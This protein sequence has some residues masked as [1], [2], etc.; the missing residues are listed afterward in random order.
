MSGLINGDFG[1]WQRGSTL[2]AETGFRFGPDMW[3]VNSTGSRVA[4]HRERFL[5]SQT[6]VP[7]N[8][9]YHVGITV[10]SI[11]GSGN[12]ARFGQPIE[13]VRRYAGETVTWSFHA[14][15]DTS[16][17]IA[18][19][20][21]QFFGSGSP[22]TKSCSNGVQKIA[23]TTQWQRFDIVIDVAS[24]VGKEIGP[25]GDDCLQAVFWLDAGSS[26]D[27]RT[28]CLGH[29]SGLFEF[30]QCGLAG[31]DHSGSMGYLK[32]RPI[33]E[34]IAE[35]ERYCEKSYN[36]DVPPGSLDNKGVV[37][38]VKNPNDSYLVWIP[39]RQR[40]RT[41]EVTCFSF[42]TGAPDKVVQEYTD[43]SVHYS[44]TLGECGFFVHLDQEFEK[45]E[46]YFI[47][48]LASVEDL[49]I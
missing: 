9:N 36:L 32:P 19:E 34:R 42:N 17:N 3:A 29:Q 4:V 35:C 12:Y 16:K 45:P 21:R 33:Y 38:H 10:H 24:V 11:A 13:D 48:W 8:P 18:I 46:R 43:V 2:P 20:L 25:A 1:I 44:T 30:A 40:M 14:K 49:K 23:L 31:G 28:D 37:T 39:F 22:S 26:H 47:Q 27:S 41:P 6:D 5:P 15:S 7:G